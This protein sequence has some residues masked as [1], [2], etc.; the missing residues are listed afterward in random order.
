MT[1]VRLPLPLRDISQIV[2]PSKECP[3]YLKDELLALLKEQQIEARIHIERFQRS[4]EDTIVHPI[5]D[6]E[7]LLSADRKFGYYLKL[8]LEFN[9]QTD[10]LMFKLAWQR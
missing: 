5:F 7:L 6:D 9:N 10:A 1:P 8:Y 4:I 2:N 3:V